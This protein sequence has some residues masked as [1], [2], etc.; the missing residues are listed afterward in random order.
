MARYVATAD[1]PRPREEV[2][3]YLKDFS[4]AAQWDP[5]VADAQRLDTG[6]IKVGSEFLLVT[7]LLGRKTP[8]TYRIV[9]LHAP[10]LVVFE[11]DTGTL[12]SYDRLTFEAAGSGTRV[13]Y[14]AD[15]TLSGALKLGDPLLRLAFRWIGGRARD[16]LR[17]QLAGPST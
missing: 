4:N 6:Q 3:E 10:E 14:D 16:G 15:L 9:E 12:R 5:G 1:S 7:E 11:A 8:L 2:F 17:R 13:T